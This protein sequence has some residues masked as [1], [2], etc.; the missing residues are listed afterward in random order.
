MR[1]RIVVV[2]Q[3]RMGSKRLPGKVLEDIAGAPMLVRVV[4]R[5]ARAA[6]VDD[7]IVAT[8]D[9]P[10]DQ[11]VAE[12]C[13]GWGVACYRGR[14]D[15]V[16]DRVY[17]AARQAQA[18]VVVRITGDCPLID[19][20]VID[21]TLDA[22]LKAEPPLDF[23]A[24]RLPNGRTFPIGL[25]TEVATFDALERAW[26]E[27]TEP[28][29]REHVMPYLYEPPGRFRVLRVDHSQDLGHLRWT[30][31]TAEDLEFVRRV[32]AAFPGRTDFTWQE[33]LKLVEEQPELTAINASV[34]HKTFMDAE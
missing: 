31:D 2:I 8:T 28:Y 4:E 25:D 30:V 26:N 32:Y 34:A 17:S 10:P 29:Q 19:P 5:S 33:V 21:L 27:A 11:A 9:L 18:Q 24:N 7:V 13:R 14:A 3:A 20:A 6:Q 22:F 16:L 12:A 23:A 15:D 1:P